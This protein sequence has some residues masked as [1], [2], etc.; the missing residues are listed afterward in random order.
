MLFRSEEIA[1]DLRLKD[2]VTL[3][4]NPKVP[5]NSKVK[6]H[7]G[8]G[9]AATTQL[10][11]AVTGKASGVP[12]TASAFYESL[13]NQLQENTTGTPLTQ[14]EILDLFMRKILML[15]GTSEDLA[16]TLKYL[17]D[18]LKNDIRGDLGKYP[19][20]EYLDPDSIYRY[21]T[22]KAEALYEVVSK[23]DMASDEAIVVLGSDAEHLMPALAILSGRKAGHFTLNRSRLMSNAEYT[24]LKGSGGAVIGPT[25]YTKKTQI[26]IPGFAKEYVWQDNSLVNSTLFQIARLAMH[27]KTYPG[28][29][30]EARFAAGLRIEM[31][32]KTLQNARKASQKFTIFG[33]PTPESDQAIAAEI[34]NDGFFTRSIGLFEEFYDQHLRTDN[35]VHISDIGTTGLQPLMLYG[36]LEYLKTLDEGSS[37]FNRLTDTQKQ[38]V[39]K[40]KSTDKKIKISLVGLGLENV[41]KGVPLGG[42]MQ[43][44]PAQNSLFDILERFHSFESTRSLASRASSIMDQALSYY[45]SLVTRNLFIEK[46][47]K[48][49]PPTRSEM[50]KVSVATQTMNDALAPEA[51][52]KEFASVMGAAPGE[53]RQTATMTYAGNLAGKISGKPVDWKTFKVL[54]S[55]LFQGNPSFYNEST[56]EK[57]INQDL[58]TAVQDGATLAAFRSLIGTLVTAMIHEDT[59]ALQPAGLDDVVAEQKPYEN[60][61]EAMKKLDATLFVDQPQYA[62]SIHFME[63]L[64]R[65][66]ENRARLVAEN[67]QDVVK[68]VE[69]IVVGKGEPIMPMEVKVGQVITEVIAYKGKAAFGGITGMTKLPVTVEELETEAIRV[70]NAKHGAI[71]VSQNDLADLGLVALLKRLSERGFSIVIHTDQDLAERGAEKISWVAWVAAALTKD[72]FTKLFGIKSDQY[73]R[74]SVALCFANPLVTR[75]VNEIASQQSVSAAA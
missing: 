24:A 42:D 37:N 69:Q 56:K 72:E 50:R 52:A 71:L 23:L 8:S 48:T 46:K 19:G 26:K 34:E 10:L 14:E 4:V 28:A 6:Y 66:L 67:K 5:S 33:T 12:V 75:L 44:V 53:A 21:F 29:T 57:A 40:I 35:K 15:G 51:L 65:V 32:Q 73:G 3:A 25:G 18:H 2:V 43:I 31:E 13:T 63:L 62:G 1:K 9:V 7:I 20:L 64:L 39:R 38:M 61:I 68:L 17:V 60:T 22:E 54:Q 59:H 27:T 30:F 70:A 47:M 36:T 45:V 74:F 11:E 49:I 58:F 55:P 16:K 41:W